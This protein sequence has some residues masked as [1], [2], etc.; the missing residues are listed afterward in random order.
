MIMVIL[1]TIMLVITL[2]I[3][4]GSVKAVPVRCAEHLGHRGGAFAFLPIGRQTVGMVDPWELLDRASNVESLTGELIVVIILIY[5]NRNRIKQI[6]TKTAVRLK[7]LELPEVRV[8][9]KPAT[10]RVH[11]HPISISAQSKGIAS[12]IAP[13]QKRRPSP[14]ALEGLLSWYLRMASS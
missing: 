3:V 13:L 1:A 7:V 9:M 10:L 14:S 4:T 5:R 11:P 6:A 2:M 12:V 8:Q